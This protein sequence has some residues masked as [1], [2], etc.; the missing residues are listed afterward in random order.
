MAIRPEPLINGLLSLIPP[1]R[2]EHARFVMG[3]LRTAWIGWGQGVVI[4]MILTL[5]FIY[6][7]LTIVG[8]DF[9]IVFA[10]FSALLVVIPYFGAIFS[11]IPPILLALTVSP[12]KAALVALVYV[13]A[14]Q[15]E[16]NVIIPLV[17]ARQVK[18]HP[19]VIA[20]GV[21]VVGELFG[22]V[23]LLVSVPIL[24][25]IVIL[26]HE[27]WVKPMEARYAARTAG[28]PDVMEEPIRA[29]AIPRAGPGDG[30]DGADGS[31]HAAERAA[32]G[33]S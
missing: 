6:F 3:R 32:P 13:I 24:S 16:G 15:L 14:H 8:L 12:T 17:M 28:G 11:S 26:T 5:I 31:E 23:G 30:D 18:V 25:A 33:R 21:V 9:A 7:G 1:D 27:L 19:A 4:H 29:D 22:F 20:V 10:V 2:R